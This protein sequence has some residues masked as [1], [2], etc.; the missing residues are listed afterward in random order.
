MSQQAIGKKKE[1]TGGFGLTK[2]Q[3]AMVVVLLLGA[4]LV[5]LNQTLLSP[6]LPAI[7]ADMKVDA[8]TVQ[9]LTSGY[10]LVEAI[11]I[12][13]NAFFMGRFRTRQLFI[14]GLIVFAAGTIVAAIAPAFWAI[15]LGRCMQACATGIIMPMVFTLI[16]LVFPREKRGSAMGIVGLVIAF[17]PAIG[18]SLS[19]VLVDSVGWRALFVIVAVVAVI[20]ILAAC[21][22]LENQGPFDPATFDKPS[23]VLLAI[24]M[25]GLLY[26]L[27]SFASSENV[28]IPL[29]MMI[30]GIIFMTFFVRRQLKLEVPLL[31]VD[32]LK[33]RRFR[34]ISCI[35]PFLQ[36]MLVGSGVI[37][38]IY[39][40]SALGYSATISGLIMLPG[41][42]FGAFCG[43]LAGRFFDKH[44]VRLVAI[45]G[46]CVLA[47]SGIGMVMFNMGTSII[48]VMVVSMLL[49][50]GLQLLTTPLNTWGVNSLDNRVIQHGN[51]L[52]NTLNQVGASF[53]TALIMSL[54]ALGVVFEPDATGAE[55]VFA[56]DHIGFIGMCVILCAILFGVLVFVR[57]RKEERGMMFAPVQAKGAGSEADKAL[58]SV[59]R[60]EAVGAELASREINED[61]L[62]VG[63]FMDKAPH[64]VSR[65][66][67]VREAL[68][69]L[70]ETSTSGI[71]VV[72]EA[73]SP[74][75]FVSDGDIM[76]YLGDSTGRF[77]DAT[78]C[79][80]RIFD[81]ETLKDR[82][83]SLLDLGVMEIATKR[84]ITVKAEESIDLACRLL[85]EKRIK[86]A[87]VVSNGVFVGTLSRRNVVAALN[88]SLNKSKNQSTKN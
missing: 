80:Y 47:I 71:V 19:G 8:T 27:S 68:A 74:V 20:V 70:A 62:T 5:V 2:Q 18:P 63:M 52:L 41:A 50:I 32:V 77:V 42:V 44:G 60:S 79:V 21:K 43:L 1:S 75:G 22:A 73:G 49:T 64:T 15:L 16:L 12:P 58:S 31:K 57:D 37:F 3:T 26:G 38:P 83:E 14:G 36:A 7:M 78:M 87:P 24:G 40:Q 69:T 46:G 35:V 4:V 25:V 33:A 23:V 11:I 6:A 85:A 39:V 53:G 81:D 28:L 72:D 65:N 45:L 9:W 29:A 59:E 30:V 76:R 67:T 88:A 51:A 55:A 61:E 66:A 17:A 10:A 34:I 54:T 84:L 13:L 82:A 86:K 56:G 48:F